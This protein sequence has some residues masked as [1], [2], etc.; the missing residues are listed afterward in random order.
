MSDQKYRQR[1][2]RDG[3]RDRGESR[4]EPRPQGPPPRKEGPRGRGLGAPTSSVFRCSDCGRRVAASGGIEL[5]QV[6]PGCGTDLHACVHCTHFDPSARFQCRQPVEVVVAKK[7]KRNECVLFA[8]KRAAEFE[9]D[10]GAR[11]PD[12]ARAAFDDLFGNL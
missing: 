1:G 7:R 9:G 12:E 10:S 5:E 3:D 6:C 4:R 8:P 11:T 2:Y